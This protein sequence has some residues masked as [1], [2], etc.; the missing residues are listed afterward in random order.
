MSTEEIQEPIEITRGS[1]EPEQSEPVE[2]PKKGK[3]PL[4]QKQLDNLAKMR[5]K[6]E[7]L[8]EVKKL[9]PDLEKKSTSLA[10]PE[11]VET[12]IPS[13]PISLPTI[14]TSTLLT[15]GLFASLIGLLWFKKKTQVVVEVQPIH[16]TQHYQ[17]LQEVPRVSNL[18]LF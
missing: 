18:Q 16:R 17:N 2:I 5:R 14:S 4:T 8:K 13:L 1:V 11:K 7:V 6:K 12:S 9:V 3:K 10:E 15:T